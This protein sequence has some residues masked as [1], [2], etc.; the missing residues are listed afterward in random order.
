MRFELVIAFLVGMA[1][2]MFIINLIWSMQKTTGTLRIDHSN[3]ERDLY[4]FEID[5]LE[6]ISSKKRIT[7]HI[8][9]NAYFSQE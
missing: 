9:H 4:R 1:I 2:G 8:D 5:D 7:L 6:N 3:P